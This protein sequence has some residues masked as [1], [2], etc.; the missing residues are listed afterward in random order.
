[1]VFELPYAFLRGPQAEVEVEARVPQTPW[2]CRILQS[3]GRAWASS[4]PLH[5]RVLAFPATFPSREGWAN[6]LALRADFLLW[7][8]S[9]HARFSFC[10]HFHK[11]INQLFRR[12]LEAGLWAVDSEKVSLL[13]RY[14]RATRNSQYLQSTSKDMTKVVD[15]SKPGA[16]IS[17][18]QDQN[19]V[20]GEKKI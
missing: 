10:K 14:S 5:L 8:L 12:G 19:R 9:T 15:G 3:M 13:L 16:L 18:C 7:K 17:G 6:S 4:S 11:P 20:K 1:M 2:R